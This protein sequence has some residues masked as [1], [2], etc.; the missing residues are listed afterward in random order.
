VLSVLTCFHALAL[1]EAK[2]DLYSVLGVHKD[3][4]EQQIKQAYRKLS[5]KWHPDR[6]QKNKDKA[7][8]KFIEIGE[9]YQVL[10]DEKKR[11]L[12]DR[13]GEAGLQMD[14]D[15]VPE[16]PKPSSSQSYQQSSW[17]GAYGSYPHYSTGGYHYDH[18]NHG[19]QQY[20]QGHYFD[21]YSQSWT[22]GGKTQQ[23]HQQ[24]YQ[25]Q[26]GANWGSN[27]Q[28]NG[29]PNL[30]YGDVPGVTELST[31]SWKEMMIEN[32]ERRST[33][34]I[35][36]SPG[37]SE[38]TSLKSI[39]KEFAETFAVPGLVEVAALNCKTYKS[40]CE[41]ERGTRSFPFVSYYGPDSAAPVAYSG[42]ITLPSLKTWILKVMPDFCTRIQTEDDLRQWLVSDDKVP[43]VILFTDRKSTPP[44]MKALS[45]EFLRRVSIAI[46]TGVDDQTL[47]QRFD[48]TSRPTLLHVEDEDSL[49]GER[50]SQPLERENLSGWLSKAVGRHRSN[51]KAAVRELTPTRF[52]SGECG[53]DDSQFCMLHLSAAGARGVAARE[54]LKTAAR[55]LSN[56]PVKVFFTRDRSVGRAFGLEAGG[57]TLFRPKRQRFK[58]FSGDTTDVEELTSFVDLAIGGGP[59]PNV[60][61]TPLTMSRI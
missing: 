7:Q 8:E 46:V 57:V 52:A 38:C 39:F 41:K 22:Q 50:F 54:A 14:P 60:L 48:V 33:V 43:K 6:H 13:F 11:K 26:W 40:R 3:D 28:K 24:Q 34:V 23:Q 36:Y 15:T 18:K 29:D 21:P 2:K 45:V 32:S 27:W 53:A 47:A 59:L 20:S 16:D 30:F 5:L 17:S 37:C 10:T 61:K 19:Q 25:A 4:T 1:L 31:R 55:R 42:Q 51:L 58:V 56:D 49:S 9:A 35:F 44:L 12:Y